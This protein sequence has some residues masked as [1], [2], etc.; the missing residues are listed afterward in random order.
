MGESW[1]HG[2]LC[3]GE[4]SVAARGCGFPTRNGCREVHPGQML[5]PYQPCSRS[6]VWEHL[7]GIPRGKQSQPRGK[8]RS[9][10]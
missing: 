5:A 4:A 3:T 6:D 1:L 8:G 2:V 10:R 7:L 9:R